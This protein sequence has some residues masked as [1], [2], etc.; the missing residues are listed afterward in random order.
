MQTAADVFHASGRCSAQGS[1]GCIGKVFFNEQ[2]DFLFPLVENRMAAFQ[3][4]EIADVLSIELRFRNAV[5]GFFR[6]YGLE[7]RF[8]CAAL[9]ESFQSYPCG[10][11]PRQQNRG[12]IRDPEMADIPAGSICRAARLLS[13]PFGDRFPCRSCPMDVP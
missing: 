1:D 7:I 8:G 10:K 3:L 2:A 4:I 5:D 11:L 12:I 9:I 6:M 13:L